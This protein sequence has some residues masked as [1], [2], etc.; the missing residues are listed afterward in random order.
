MHTTTLALQV[1]GFI[2]DNYMLDGAC[3]LSDGDSF[4]DGGII[5]S[6][7]VLELVA[8]LQETFGIRVEDE[9]LTTE[10]LDSIDKVV[11]YLGR[12]LTGSGAA[13]VADGV[14]S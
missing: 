2:T 4:I 8:F 7:G 10:N 12:K 11:A 9:E 1:R 14:A 5:D 6:T 3:A 13:A